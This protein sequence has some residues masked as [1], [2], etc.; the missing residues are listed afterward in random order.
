MVDGRRGESST[1]VYLIRVRGGLGKDWEEWFENMTITVEQGVSTLCGPLPDQAA[2][3]GVLA[4][5]RD[6]ALPLISVQRVDSEQ[7]PSEPASTA[8]D[9]QLGR[10]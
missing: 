8:G 4:K 7:N 5:I 9:L 1:A 2:L 6:L 10:E 3:H